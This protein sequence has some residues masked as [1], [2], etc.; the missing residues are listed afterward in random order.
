MPA[1]LQFCTLLSRR[2]QK[3]RPF[4][5]KK[6]NDSIRSYPPKHMWKD[7]TFQDIRLRRSFKPN[8]G[9]I[10]HMSWTCGSTPLTVRARI[11]SG[12]QTLLLSCFSPTEWPLCP[13]DDAVLALAVR[14]SWNL[15]DWSAGGWNNVPSRR[16]QSN[17]FFQV[18][19]SRR[20]AGFIGAWGFIQWL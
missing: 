7:A 11:S 9:T 8:R 5:T 19:L 10:E 4:I 15:Y 12:S 16:W 17:R 6:S 1:S 14:S 2:V 18:S 20:V 3:W 13:M